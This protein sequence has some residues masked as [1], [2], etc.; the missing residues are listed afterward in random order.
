MK[1]SLFCQQ[2]RHQRRNAISVPRKY[3]VRALEQRL[4]PRHR[5][6]RDPHAQAHGAISKAEY[7]HTDDERSIRAYGVNQPAHLIERRAELLRVEP[8]RRDVDEYQPI[9]S[10]KLGEPIHL[11]AA[12]RA[13]TV[14]EEGERVVSHSM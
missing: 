3:G 13:R 9:Q 7:I 5:Q 2:W 11:D 6:W 10:V 12:D 8:V 4:Q 14:E 1:L